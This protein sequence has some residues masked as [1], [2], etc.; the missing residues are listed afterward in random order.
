M[1]SIEVLQTRSVAYLDNTELR[2]EPRNFG[3]ELCY[4]RSNFPSYLCSKNLPIK[5]LSS[6]HGLVMPISKIAIRI[7]PYTEGMSENREVMSSSNSIIIQHFPMA[8]CWILRARASM[9]ELLHATSWSVQKVKARS[10]PELL[11]FYETYMYVQH[12][13]TLPPPPS[14]FTTFYS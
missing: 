11:P 8:I 13:S 3:S 14:M 2:L 4:V 7:T 10:H 12:C 6:C 5:I 9:H 1:P